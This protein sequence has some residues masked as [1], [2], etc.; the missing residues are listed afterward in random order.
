MRINFKDILLKPIDILDNVLRDYK[1]K[2]SSIRATGK[3]LVNKTDSYLSSSEKFYNSYAESREYVVGR[4]AAGIWY[5]DDGKV[6]MGD[7]RNVGIELAIQFAIENKDKK[8][9]KILKRIE[10]YDRKNFENAREKYDIAFEMGVSDKKDDKKIEN[11]TKT[12]DFLSRYINYSYDEL[13]KLRK[14]KKENLG[15]FIL[16][17]SKSEAQKDLE[18]EIEL[19]DKLI[20]TKKSKRK[21]VLV[22]KKKEIKE[23]YNMAQ[24]RDNKLYRRYSKAM[25]KASKYETIYRRESLSDVYNKASDIIMQL[26]KSVDV[27]Y[28]KYSHY[29]SG[30]EFLETPEVK[31]NEHML[32]S[33]KQELIEKYYSN[34]KGKSL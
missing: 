3:E 27:K 19:L 6:V 30:I 18:K 26:S 2:I 24:K 5:G 11:L 31:I 17:G 1:V 10:K 20:D 22:A 8:L 23:I 15:N 29:S 14:S 33:S 13:Y 34:N 28:Y 16:R 25:R 12:I 7:Y 32:K 9:L 21:K 4:N